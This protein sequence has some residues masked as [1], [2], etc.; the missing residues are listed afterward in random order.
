MKS[1]EILLHTP[2]IKLDQLLKFAGIVETGGQAKEKIAAGECR[3]NDEVCTQ[4]GKKI[5]PGDTVTIAGESAVHV[6]KE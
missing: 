1:Q 5:Y 3:I 4:R 6:G 2:F